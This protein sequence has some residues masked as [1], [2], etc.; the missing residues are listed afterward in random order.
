MVS[1]SKEIEGWR[2]IGPLRLEAS[3][4]EFQHERIVTAERGERA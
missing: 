2:R 1:V 4:A 3:K